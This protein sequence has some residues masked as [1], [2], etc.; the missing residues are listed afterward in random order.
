ML[1][2]AE[3][4]FNQ[5]RG[6]VEKGENLD[7][8]AEG[9]NRLLNQTI[10]GEGNAAHIL[11]YLGC[12]HMK[13]K[14]LAMALLVFRQAIKHKKDFIEAINNLGY[15][16]K[17]AGLFDDARKCFEQ[18][19]KVVSESPETVPEKD[20]SDYLT[21]IGSLLIQNGTPEKALDLFNQALALEG[22][23]IT[24]KWN[25]SLALLE[26]GRYEEGFALYDFGERTERCRTRDYGVK[27]LPEWDGTP[28][29]TVVVYGE[30]GIGD[31]IMFASVIP[32]AMKDITIILDC[33]PR[34]IDIFRTNFPT[35]ALYGT[36]KTEIQSVEWK[37]FHKID[38]KIA[39]GSLCRFYRK[40]LEDFPRLPYLRADEKLSDKWREKL[41][42][43]G[44]RP[45]IGIS[46][47]GGTRSTGNNQRL[48]P[49]EMWVD[50]FKNVDAD[51]ISLQYNKGM[52]EDID[53]FEKKHGVC[54]NHWPEMVYDYDETAGLV[55]NL[56]LVISA[57]QSVVH[58]AGALGVPTWQLAP[59]RAMWQVG[60]YGENMPWYITNENIWQK[61]VDDWSTVMTEVKDRLCSSLQTNTKT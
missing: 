7:I 42:S 36:R 27:D 43:M 46:W 21:N 12:I 50:I 31:E 51:F 59:I 24:T 14:E 18:V 13:K 8:A 10:H 5:S 45:K 2:D 11:F 35:L 22:C 47:K 26:L 3:V 25:K 38:A 53:A 20:K 4:L 29:K 32:D 49:L 54:I 28:G 33:H 60:V 41:D 44:N 55:Q 17:E 37:G 1:I 52:E 19:W 57:P 34:L 23:G 61:N 48:I 39:M 30:Q 15:T 56:D 16:F 40:R 6:L 9:F 58:L